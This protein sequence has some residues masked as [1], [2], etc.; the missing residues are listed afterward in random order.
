MVIRIFWLQLMKPGTH[1]AN[2][3]HV[4]AFTKKLFRKQPGDLI[5]HS[6]TLRS[7]PS[8]KGKRGR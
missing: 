8:Y 2:K 4:L 5:L 3:D 7:P 6:P 1:L